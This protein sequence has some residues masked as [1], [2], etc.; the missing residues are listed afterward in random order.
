MTE[1]GNYQVDVTEALQSFNEMSEE[2]FD[3]RIGRRFG[4]AAVHNETSWL[5]GRVVPEINKKFN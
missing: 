1:R 3:V 4:D 2:L 5:K